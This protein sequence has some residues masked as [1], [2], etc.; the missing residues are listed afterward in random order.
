MIDEK[1]RYYP[2]SVLS[3]KIVASENIKLACTRYLSRFDRPDME[4]RPEKVDRVVKFIAKLSHSVGS[5]S[6]FILSDWEF[7]IISNIFGWYWKE[8]G[9][10]VTKNVYIEVGRKNGKTALLAAICLYCLMADGES[11][12]EVDCVANSR[13]QASILMDMI[14]HFAS[15]IDPSEKYLKRLRRELR[16]EATKSIAQVL[17]SDAKRLDGFNASVFVED[18]LHEAKDSRLY[19]VLK[20]SQGMRVQPL[21]VCITS[22]GYNKYSFCYQ[23]RTTCIEILKGLKMDE[24]QFSAIYSIDEG[25]DWKDPEVWIKANP[26]LGVTVRRENLEEA[27]VRA[28]NDPTQETETKIKH[29]GVWCDTQETWISSNEI[30]KS[31]KNLDIQ[32]FKGMNAWMGV[33]L[34]ASSDLT[35]VSVMIPKED[36]YYFITKYYLPTSCLEGNANSYKY[37]EWKREGYLTA[38]PGN[39]IDY[40]YILSDMKNWANTLIVQKVAYDSW[41]ATQWAIDATSEG[42]PLEPYGQS[43]GNFNRPTKELERLI[44]MGKVVIDN[45]PVTRFCFSN[46]VIKCDHNQNEKPT[47]TTGLNKIDG[48][49]AMIQALGIKLNEPQF[50]YEIV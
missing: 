10:R 13:L 18:E 20:S 45:N 31:T 47:K 15:T 32:D 34:S 35:A 40:D 12:A 37:R 6:S 38:I 23:M 24:S 17:A 21:A 33:D 4:F 3:G 7:W 50:N 41:N 46:V 43:I 22:A 39:V 25:D 28:T 11:G 48:V 29:F 14:S 44:L 16:F 42:L 27:V 2:E 30:E 36:K 19:G 26:N 5:K 9:K 49:I 1:Y 8:T